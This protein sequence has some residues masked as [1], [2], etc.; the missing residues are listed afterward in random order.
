[1]NG[2]QRHPEQPVPGNEPH[3][4]LKV[5]FVAVS[6]GEDETQPAVSMC[7]S[8]VWDKLASR[9]LLFSLPFISFQGERDLPVL[10][11]FAF[12]SL[13]APSY[14]SSPTSVSNTQQPHLCHSMLDFMRWLVTAFIYV[15]QSLYQFLEDLPTPFTL[16]RRLRLL[17]Q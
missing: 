5:L 1:M 12:H 4:L 16:L 10:L 17:F 11:L 2:N 14:L 7:G 15:L 13:P 8:S 6:T 3:L 9:R